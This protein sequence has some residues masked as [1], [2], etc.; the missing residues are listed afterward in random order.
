MHNGGVLEAAD[1]A[2]LK[3]LHGICQTDAKS[4][5]THDQMNTIF[6]AIKSAIG[7]L[8][9]EYTAHL[10]GAPKPE[11]TVGIAV[12]KVGRASVCKAKFEPG[13]ESI[14]PA[15]SKAEEVRS[16]R[17]E[18]SQG[19]QKTECIPKAQGSVKPF[20]SIRSFL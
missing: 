10:P 12:Q 13:F 1:H 8:I 2:K 11:D 9:L 15:R 5:L 7:G 19:K 16:V 6:V 14:V 3:V 4:F 18:P 20:W 17:S